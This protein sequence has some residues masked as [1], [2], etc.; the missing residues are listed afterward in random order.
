MA[1]VDSPDSFQIGRVVSRTF[2]VL[3]HNAAVILII[4]ALLMLPM[5]LV[6]FYTTRTPAVIAA[7]GRSG[8]NLL[9]FYETGA[10]SFLVLTICTYVLQAAVI[11]GTL[12]YL[13]GEPVR[14]G[15]C[16]SAG[17]RSFLPIVVIAFLSLLG[18]TAG[19]I[20]L[21]IPG[22]ILALAWSVVIPVRVVENTGISESFGRSRALTKDHRWKILALFLLYF[23]AAV[24]IELVTAPFL[25]ISILR[26]SL[27]SAMAS[28]AVV[29]SWIE[30]V[31]FSALTAVGI[32]SIYYELRLV[33]EGVGA[34]QLAAAFD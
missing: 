17:F 27:A 16:L 20:L 26:P 4:S 23:L 9:K 13:N 31:V 25:G 14:L 28:P 11:R 8:A 3:S 18:M 7:A 10:V 33:K 19:M 22:I 30:R 32:A 2:S 5:L 15:D 24:V 21:V 29:V 1:I 12:T 6:S 34:S